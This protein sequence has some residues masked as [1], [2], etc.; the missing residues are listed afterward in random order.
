MKVNVIYRI[1]Y[2]PHVGIDVLPK[3]YIGS[4]YDLK[5][6]R[7]YLG[8][9][10]SGQIFSYTEGLSL[11]NWWK[12]ETRDRPDNFMFEVISTEPHDITPQELVLREKEHQTK[13][14]ICS[15]EY[16]NQGI[17]TVGFVSKKRSDGVKRDIAEK[18]R[19]YW[20]T[21]AGLD[22]KNRLSE[23][24]KRTKSTELKRKWEDEDYRK[25]HA[26]GMSKIV[27][28]FA[29]RSSR[30]E[31]ARIKRTEIIKYLDGIYFGWDDLKEKTG[32]TKFLYRK[33][34]INGIDPVPRIG[35][36]RRVTL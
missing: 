26:L 9:P 33:Y 4:K 11:K 1:T 2:L 7:K 28:S 18:T 16:F 29:E 6:N 23:R 35:N 17:A 32:V 21:P 8:S 3:Y 5:I 27:W 12:R 10:S 30:S 25:K 24:N 31:R 22:K 20:N 13:V 36:R 15:V 14:N 19:A 34:Y